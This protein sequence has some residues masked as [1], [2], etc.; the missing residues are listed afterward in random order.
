MKR[1]ATG[2]RRK[3]RRAP[4]SVNGATPS[5]DRLA[6]LDRPRI[7][8]LAVA[9]LVAVF[10]WQCWTAATRW[11]MTSDEVVHI[12]AGYVYWKLGDFTFNAEHPPLAKLLA[13][14]PLLFTRPTLPALDGNVVAAGYSFCFRANDTRSILVSPRLVIALLGALLVVVVFLWGRALFGQRAGLLAAFLCAFE[15]NLTAHASVVTTD[16][17]MTLFFLLSVAILWAIARRVTW[18]RV[19]GFSLAVA[20]AAT[21]KFSAVLLIPILGALAAVVAL[22]RSELAWSS[23]V[24]RVAGAGSPTEV[25]GRGGKA[26]VLA[27]VFALALVVCVAAIWAAYGFSFRGPDKADAMH[28]QSVPETLQEWKRT[29]GG[30]VPAQPYEFIDRHRLLPH[31]FVVGLLNVALHNARGHG[32]FLLGKVSDFGRPGYFPFAVLVK[33]PLPFLLLLLLGAMLL[34]RR[35]TRPAGRLAFLVVPP[36]VYMLASMASNLNIG[37]RH[38]LPVYPFMAIAAGATLAA[39]PR[40]SAGARRRVAAAIVALAAW[41]AFEG[42]RYRPHFLSYFNQLAGG[43]EQGYRVLSD[44][45]VDWGQDLYLLKQWVETHDAGG[46]KVS[47]FGPAQPDVDAGIPCEY[48]TPPAMSPRRRGTV[49]LRAGDLLAV[50]ATHLAGM[51]GVRPYGL[52]LPLMQHEPLARVGYSIFIYRIGEPQPR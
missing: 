30:T 23:G 35:R 45:N 11:S 14:V 31:A 1:E 13:T 38:V 4:L 21:T 25:R 33:T 36:A 32:A 47:Y 22:D 49:P 10:A 43:P 39:L 27:G 7:A 26:A 12:P 18:P 15:P 3:Q 5:H 44:S 28:S 37:V 40:L 50:S 41:H 16:V 51:R 9:L 20:A 6:I 29:L 17:P 42:V 52:F 34:L 48:V 19:A 24:R 46:L 2:Q 8:A